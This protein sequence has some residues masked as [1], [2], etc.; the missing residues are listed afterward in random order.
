MVQVGDQVALILRCE[1][2]I[3]VVGSEPDD[4]GMALK[5]LQANTGHMVWPACIYGPDIVGQAICRQG[6]TIATSHIIP[7][8]TIHKQNRCRGLALKD[9]LCAKSGVCLRPG[10]EG[11]HIA[12]IPGY[13]RRHHDLYA[14]GLRLASTQCHALGNLLREG[15]I[16]DRAK[17][18]RGRECQGIPVCTV[19]CIQ[20]FHCVGDG[21]SM[22][23]HFFP[24]WRIQFHRQ[25]WMGSSQPGQS[26]IHHLS[27]GGLVAQPLQASR[28]VDCTIGLASS[29][30]QG[31]VRTLAVAAKYRGPSRVEQRDSVGCEL[32]LSTVWSVDWE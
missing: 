11:D 1:G 21:C 27:P 8:V 19:A 6:C 16:P 29:D 14:Q 22:Q 9:S 15:T 23:P 5:P 10:G 20:Q 4:Y 2:S 25:V 28:Q 12:G 7:P 18:G 26:P 31:G 3:P 13:L 30:L 17:P 32:V 24:F